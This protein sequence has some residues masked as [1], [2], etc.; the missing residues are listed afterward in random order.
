MLGLTRKGRPILETSV[1]FGADPGPQQSA[2][3]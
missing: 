2:R 1:G 3:R